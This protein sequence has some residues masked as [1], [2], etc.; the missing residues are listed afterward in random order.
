MQWPMLS[1]VNCKFQQNSFR[2]P[3]LLHAGNTELLILQKSALCG[4]N[5]K[6]NDLGGL[7]GVAAQK[8]LQITSFR[9]GSGWTLG[10]ICSPKEWLGIGTGCPGRW[11]SHHPW[12]SSRNMEMWQRGFS[13]LVGIVG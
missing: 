7:E 12:N 1:E 11:W 10:K 8:M 9:G 13:G 3:R 6:K 4:E 2:Y 5:R